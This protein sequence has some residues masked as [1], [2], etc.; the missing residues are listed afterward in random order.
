MKKLL[1]A[2]C[3]ATLLL[4]GCNGDGNIAPATPDTPTGAEGLH[5]GVASLSTDAVANARDFHALVTRDDRLWLVYTTDAGALAGSLQGSG[6]SSASADTY[7][8][9]SLVE[10]NAGGTLTGAM[11]ATFVAESKLSGSVLSNPGGTPRTLA[12][13]PANAVTFAT[14]YLGAPAALPGALT[15]Y[16]GEALAQGGVVEATLTL[17][18]GVAVSNP[19]QVLLGQVGPVGDV[20]YFTSPA[21]ATT[22]GNY[23]NVTLTFLGGL[24]CT[25]RGLSGSV[26]GVLYTT[27]AGKRVLV[28]RDSRLAFLES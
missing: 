7:T 28:T 12:L 3:G 21:T 1:L 15:N 25:D 10:R 9:A 19:N 4:T 18:P 16:T 23:F 8:A 11:A 20:C 2:A 13:N 24:P 27:P 22:Q 5:N 26:T 6:A 17:D 14:A